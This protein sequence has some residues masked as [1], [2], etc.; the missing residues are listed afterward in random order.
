MTN[1]VDI[2]RNSG[3]DIAC[4]IVVVEL[5]V[6]ILDVIEQHFTDIVYQLLRGVLIHQM[7]GLLDNASYQRKADHCNKHL[8]QQI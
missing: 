4:T 2:A 1:H 8:Y 5:S 3:H 7:A 6:L